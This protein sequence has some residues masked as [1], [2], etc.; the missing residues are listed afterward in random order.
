MDL[1]KIFVRNMKYY[2]KSAGL[3]QEKLAALCD[4]SHSYIRQIECG[5]R[6][7]SFSF[8]GKLA[9]ALHIP[10]A[11][12]FIDKEEEQNYALSQKEKIKTELLEQLAQNVHSAFS[13]L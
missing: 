5:S 10:V 3:S 8:M 12:L 6:Y 1:S 2:R 13:K 7:P 4:A 9:A 11:F